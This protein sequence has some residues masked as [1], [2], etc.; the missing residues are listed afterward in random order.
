MQTYGNDREMPPSKKPM[1]DFPA[2]MVHSG[3]QV[4]KV[5]CL[6]VINDGQKTAPISRMRVEKTFDHLISLRIQ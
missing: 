5:H 2:K 3:T 1:N 6:S 4:L